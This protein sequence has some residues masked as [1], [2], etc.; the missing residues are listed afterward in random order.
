VDVLQIVVELVREALASALQHLQ[1][2]ACNYSMLTQQNTQAVV[3][4][5]LVL[6]FA[7]LQARIQQQDNPAAQQALHD[8]AQRLAHDPLID[9]P[10]FNQRLTEAAWAYSGLTGPAAVV[11]FGSLYYPPTYVA[12]TTDRQRRLRQ[13]A[14]EQAATLSRATHTPICLRPF[15]PG[16]SDISFLGSATTTADITAMARNTPAWDAKLRFDYAAISALDMPTINIGPWG[17]DYHQR[18]ERVYM[19]Y[20]F[21]IVPELIWRIA[22]Q[23]LGEPQPSI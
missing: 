14:E 6:T 20:S 4:Q 10:T 22:G 8:L 13:I 16:I 17:R 2:Q 9:L 1:T 5:P 15:F 7:E 21:E 3:W 11:G 23:L 12:G 19:P 18:L